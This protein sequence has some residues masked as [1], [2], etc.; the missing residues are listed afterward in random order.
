[1]QL[2][3]LCHSD[4]E[5]AERVSPTLVSKLGID[6]NILF[7]CSFGRQQRLTLAHKKNKNVRPTAINISIV[8][9]AGVHCCS[10]QSSYCISL[11]TLLFCY[12]SLVSFFRRKPDIRPKNLN[13]HI[14]YH[15]L[16]T[17]AAAAALWQP[18]PRQDTK[19]SART[20]LH[21]PQ[22]GFLQRP[23]IHH[24]HLAVTTIVVA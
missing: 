15:K 6:H 4:F 7:T 11:K 8:G 18:W 16:K 9:V 12:F 24:T 21:A 10:K 23:P 20:P 19:N 14:E 17:A 22:G 1:M 13:H 3:E 5:C 2:V